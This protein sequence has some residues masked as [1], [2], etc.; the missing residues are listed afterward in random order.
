MPMLIE[1]TL[2]LC[3]GDKEL[4]S[5]TEKINEEAAVAEVHQKISKDLT[6]DDILD[7]FVDGRQFKVICSA[8]FTFQIRITLHQKM[9]YEQRQERLKRLKSNEN[10]G[11]AE[12]EPKD[13]EPKDPEPQ[14]ESSKDTV[15]ATPQI[16]QLGS[17][18]HESIAQS[19]CPVCFKE[20]GYNQEQHVY[21]CTSCN[22]RF[23]I[24]GSELS[25]S[26]HGTSAP[27]RTD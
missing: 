9:F 22:R 3:E 14:K 8:S 12:S 7:D 11:V 20:V 21:I 25:E 10:T 26:A 19:E 16:I 4:A 24:S 17:D 18:A 2:T 27:N 1:R 5:Y 6:D 23:R 13:P 15:D